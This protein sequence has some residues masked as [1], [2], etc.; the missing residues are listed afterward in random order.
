MCK[1]ENRQSMTSSIYDYDPTGYREWFVN[2]LRWK[3]GDTNFADVQTNQAIQDVIAVSVL[4]AQIPYTFYT[5]NKTNNLLYMRERAIGAATPPTTDPYATVTIVPGNYNSG[6]IGAA[7]Q[8]AIAAAGLT[9]SYT[10]AFSIISGKLTLSSSNKQFDLL[11]AIPTASPST[12]DDSPGWLPKCCC[13]PIGLEFYNRTN[14]VNVT[15]ITFPNVVSLSGPSWIMLRGTF[16]VGGADNLILCDDGTVANLGNVLAAIPV[17]TVPG[18]TISWRNNAPRGGF[19]KV[20]ADS[21][22]TA[23][24]WLTSGDDD[25]PL[26]LNGQPF[27]FKLAF[28]VKSSGGS[29]ASGSAYTKDRNVRTSYRP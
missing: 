27:Q 22:E 19:F 17:N 23:R 20:T 24:F 14:Y 26:D 28:L 25:A 9:G 8:A 11:T 29:T 10:V 4:E 15:S 21:V 13:T 2:S 6:N 16:G 7:I 1:S 3:Y 12:W 5:I 18:S